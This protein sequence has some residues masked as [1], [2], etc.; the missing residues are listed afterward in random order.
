MKTI[1]H[2]GNE[3]NHQLIA[4]E[5]ALKEAFH[6]EE[7]KNE[8]W[9]LTDLAALSDLSEAFPQDV[10]KF[11]SATGW[12]K[13]EGED[14]YRLTR[15]GRARA[16]ELIRAHRLWEQYLATYEGRQ[17]ESLHAEAHQREHGMSSEEVARLDAVLGYP[18]WDPHGHA[19]PD[20]GGLVP[21]NAGNPLSDVCVPG[22]AFRVV[23]VDDHPEE[24]LA[25]FVALGIVPGTELT[26]IALGN[27]IIKIKTN[28]QILPLALTAASHIFVV[29]AVET[30][31]LMGQMAVGE[32]AQILELRGKGK[33]QRRLL[34]M[35]FVPGAMI[36][37]VREAPFGDPFL[38]RIKKSNVALRRKEADA[39]LV[40][41]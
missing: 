12:I 31:V 5:D 22:S 9:M 18:V 2:N 39:V 30:S 7:D 19:I 10:G 41:Q 13:S 37:I 20:E 6:L 14:Q 1:K 26:I 35:G 29:P 4:M 34:S 3:I 38:C 17:L 25:Q 40:K 33:L 23:A 36:S 24:L 11:L 32:S 27:Q 15:S 28:D 16:V 21:S 8:P